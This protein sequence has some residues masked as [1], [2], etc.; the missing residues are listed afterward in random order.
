M[1]ETIFTGVSSVNEP[2]GLSEAGAAE[3]FAAGLVADEELEPQAETIRT[4]EAA[5]AVSANAGDRDIEATPEC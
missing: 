5:H 4:A 2:A 1:I 3:P